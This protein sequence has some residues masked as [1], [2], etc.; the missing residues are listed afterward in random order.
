MTAVE[1][2]TY[3]TRMAEVCPFLLPGAPLT[4]GGVFSCIDPYFWASMG[5]ALSISLSILG[6]AWSLSYSLLFL[7]VFYCTVIP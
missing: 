7:F 4:W 2:T 1:Y 5:I 6:A 3:L